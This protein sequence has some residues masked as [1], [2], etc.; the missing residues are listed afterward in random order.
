MLQSDLLPTTVGF[1]IALIGP[2]L[3]A[4]RGS[5][6]SSAAGSPQAMLIGQGLLICLLIGILAVV[7][8]WEGRTMAFLGLG[9][10]S[11]ASLVWGI[12]LASSFIFVLGPLLFRLPKWLGFAGFDA[13][14]ADL[15]GLPAWYLVIAVL[16]GGTVEEI[17]YRGFALNEIA[18]LIG[19]YWIAGTITVLA[20]AA[21]HVPTWGW[22]PAITTTISGAIFTAFYIWRQDL[23]TTI[24]AHVLIDFVGIALGPVIARVHL[25]REKSGRFP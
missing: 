4:M 19:S 6:P 18:A 25:L 9:R 5:S 15:K 13:P 1:A 21:A 10:P 17:L 23:W 22:G 12:A 20:F 16:I 2:P 24:I 8:L 11:V 3:V 7:L 14:L